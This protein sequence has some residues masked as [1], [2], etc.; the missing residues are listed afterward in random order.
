M[1]PKVSM[2]ENNRPVI[3]SLANALSLIE[4]L[5]KSAPLGLSE[6]AR[7][8]DI[9][10]A[11]L[12]RSLETLQAF[13]WVEQDPPP[14]SSW[15]LTEKFYALGQGATNEDRLKEWSAEALTDLNHETK[16]T[17]HLAAADINHLILVERLDSAFALRAHIPLGAILP[18]HASATGLAYLS[19]LDDA[20]IEQKLQHLRDARTPNTLTEIDEIMEAVQETRQRGFS[21]NDQGLSEGISSVGAPILDHHA[22][23][24]GAISISGPSSR[25]TIDRQLEVGPMVS[26]AAAQVT[27]RIRLLLD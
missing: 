13:A 2:S 1:I 7:Q 4:L 21:L 9:S 11:T 20:E 5:A 15:R 17:V 6:A 10:K 24:I 18:F 3:R 12:L 19:A 16:E 22:K 25:I 26:N 8:L 27:A 23:P 14:T